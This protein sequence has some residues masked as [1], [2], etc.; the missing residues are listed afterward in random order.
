M[1]RFL[2]EVINPTTKKTRIAL[3]ISFVFAM[4]VSFFAF[5]FAFLST[6]FV[7]TYAGVDTSTNETTRIVFN[8]NNTCEYV[9][10]SEGNNAVFYDGTW[11]YLYAQKKDNA[12]SKTV[13]KDG[14]QTTID[15]RIM[16]NGKKEQ[17][18][19][20]YVKKQLHA[21]WN[22]DFCLRKEK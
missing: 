4:I 10:S 5:F 20:Y 19:F 17:K 6:S 21:Y 11:T 8:L 15:I 9:V 2:K 22:F 13:W 14:T 16:I 3:V 1:N 12:N 7:G 18:Q